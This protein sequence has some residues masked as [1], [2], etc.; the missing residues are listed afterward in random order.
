MYQKNIFILFLFFALPLLALDKV[1]LQLKWHHQFQFAGYYAALE[2]GYYRDEGLDVTIKDRD[3]EINNIDQVLNGDSQYGISDSVL[4]VY[5]AQKKPIAIVAPIFQH[6]PSVFIALKSSGI[7]SPYKM[8]GKRI[9]LYPNDADGLPLLA[10]LYETG[11]TQQGFKRMQT[12]F[13]LDQLT[14]GDVDVIYAYST[15]EPYALQKK[16]FDINVIYP[17]NFGIDLYGDILFTTQDEL[18]RHPKRVAAM[19]RATIKGWEYAIAHKEEIVRLIQIKYHGEQTTDQL[20]NEAAG[21]ITAIDAS[22]IPIGSLNQGRLD[23]M[24]AML[25]RHGLVGAPVSLDQYV[26]R[27]AQGIGLRVLEYISLDSIV[28]ANAILLILLIISIYYMRQLRKQK[29]ELRNLSEYLNQAKELAEE[30]AHS[31]SAF[32][33]A[34]SHEIRT[35]MN[36]VLGMLRLLEDSNLDTSQQHRLDIATSSATSLLGLINDILDFSKIEAGKMDLENIE[37]NLQS[38]LK[39]LTDSMSFKAHEKGLEFILNTAKINYPNIITDPGRLRQILTNLTSNAIKFTPSG[40]IIIDV[41]LDTLNKSQGRLHIDIIDSGIG[42]SPEAIDKLFEPFIQADGSTTRKYGGTGLGLSIVKR[43]CELMGGSVYVTSIPDNGSTFS[44]DLT[45]QLGGNQSIPSRR[46]SSTIE[47][48]NDEVVWPPQ[49]RILLV[50]DNPTNQIV[51]QSMLE[52]MGLVADIADNGLE[53]IEAI[54]NATSIHPYSIILMDCQMPE[55][56]GYD[57]TRAVRS[58]Q[59]GESNSKI[60]IIAMTANAMIGDREKCILAG[61][62]DYIP[63]PINLTTL[64]ETMIQ[65]LLHKEPKKSSAILP[66][67]QQP[68]ELLLWDKKEA[69]ALVGGKIE[70]LDKIIRSFLLHSDNGLNALRTAIQTNNFADAKLLAHSMKGSAGN[71][72]V[73]KLQAIARI[74]EEAAKT[75]NPLLL[76]EQLEQYEETLQVTVD[77]LERHLAAQIK[78]SS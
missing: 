42:I 70:L 49:T 54:K 12:H 43:L 21:I 67:V 5:Q 13:D 34:M 8:I 76:E 23:Y 64:K 22:S 59:A 6:S 24:Q 29:K 63:K 14:S 60:P 17:Q 53:A 26:Y 74:L 44:V 11:V 65:W 78:E 25:E 16:G 50:E 9:A 72:G 39:E 69:L 36:G 7:N 3:P 32:L 4:L 66:E 58:G 35:P 10:M 1:S 31:K 52:T 57:A 41:S 27:N 45:V 2:Q 33:A 46:T 28:S 75:Q 51:A 62:D 47:T 30:S 18:A 20:L 15:N 19:K 77:L 40:I 73:F 61:M 38:E 48:I 37:V 68:A 56:D 55:M 71:T